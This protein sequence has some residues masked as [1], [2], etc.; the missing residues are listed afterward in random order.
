[1]SA[2]PRPTSRPSWIAP[3]RIRRPGVG[4]PA[5]TTS[6]CPFHA[7]C[8]RPPSRSR[9]PRWGVRRPSERSRVGTQPAEDPAATSAASSSVPP[10]FSYGPR[11]GS[12]A[13]EHLVRID[14]IGD[15]LG[16][17]RR[18]IYHG[19]RC[20]LLTISPV[21]CRRRSSRIP[22]VPAA[23][24]RLAAVLAPLI[25]EP[26]PSL[27]FTVRAAAMSRHAGEISFPGGLQIRASRWS[28]RCCAR[29]TRN[30]ASTPAP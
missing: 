26:E 29:R 3:P 24:D 16:Q 7:R 21:R 5:G 6:R 14:G 22:T 19:A 2:E 11:S 20:Y 17:V 13:G 23:G 12:R 10:G 18:L 25:A 30:S 27:I 8:G 4:R 9:R 28:R 15:G 1:M